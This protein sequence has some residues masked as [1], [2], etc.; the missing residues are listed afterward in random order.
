MNLWP[1]EK[2]KNLWNRVTFLV[3][4]TTIADIMTYC[5]RV[6]FVPCELESIKGETAEF[7]CEWENIAVN[8]E[9]T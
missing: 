7:I 2:D 9:M 3:A 1:K 4:L 6:K 8:L 5:S